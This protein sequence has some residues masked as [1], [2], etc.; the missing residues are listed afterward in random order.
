MGVGNR[1]AWIALALFGCTE[2]VAPPPIDEPPPPPV[3][4]PVE[5]I[6]SPGTVVLPR[7]TEKQYR[8]TLE[9]L[10]GTRASKIAVETDTNPYLFYSIGATSTALSERGAQSYADA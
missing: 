3:D 8:N 1:T 4:P 6:F 7:L 2:A 10:F 5:K 9:D